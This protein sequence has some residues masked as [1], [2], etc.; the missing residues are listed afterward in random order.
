MIIERHIG[1]AG[2]GKTT[3]ILDKLSEYRDSLGL[4][5]EEIGCCTFTR[6]GRQEISERA[7]ARWGCDTERLTK[8][9]WFRT[10]HSI[11]HRQCNVGQG[12][13][14]EGQDGAE[15]VSKAVGGTLATKF[16]A[17]SNAVNYVSLDGDNSAALALKAWDIARAKGVSIDK[18]IDSWKV[19]GE[20][21]LDVHAAAS[22]LRRYERAKK[23]ED[24]LDF[25]DMIARFAG[26]RYSLD[27]GVKFVDPEGDTPEGM[28]ILAIDE[29]QDSSLLVD[30]VCRR[31]AESPS[32][33]YV[34]LA[35]DPFQSIHGFAGGDFRLFMSWEAEQ[36]IMPRSYRCPLVIQKMGE[37][38]LRRMR[39][40]YFERDVEPAPH[41]GMIRRLWGVDEALSHID[42]SEPTLILGRCGF[43]LEPY[44]QM[45]V[46]RDIPFTWIDKAH[47]ATQMLGYEA[48]WRLQNGKVINH[49]DWQAAIS[50]TQASL[51]VRGEKTAWKDGRRYNIDIIWP[52]PEDLEKAGAKPVL[53]GMIKEGRW[54]EC[55][56]KGLR[57][58][59]ERWCRFA[60]K[61]GPE[62]ASQPKV[63]LSTI[64]SAKGCEGDTVIL[65]TTSSTAV[66]NAR[67]NLPESHDEEC[68]VQYV[69]VTRA[70]R[71]LLIVDDGGFSRMELPL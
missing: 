67:M 25:T 48:F 33:E 63:R 30:R 46:D 47:S 2:S 26:M 7:A 23:R 3:L 56:D 52:T 16:D 36:F 58:K 54:S 38:C 61:Y 59:A 14:I 65:S 66:E 21:T 28:R 11:A 20:T 53:F 34:M 5:P 64:H 4:S 41:E 60:K 70:R 19:I 55:L 32:I 22:I 45:L 24:R 29:A 51:L 68:R 49:D 1:H 57:E 39:H 6:A 8:R 18:V 62:V 12:Q 69:G 31:L 44:E 27:D 9:G 42:P 40:G 10:A 50:M 35:G 37:R 71:N 43:S 13:L 15:W 17:R